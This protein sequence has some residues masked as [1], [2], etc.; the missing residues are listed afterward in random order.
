MSGNESVRLPRPGASILVILMGSLGD[1][2]RGFCILAP[3]KARLPECRVS[4]L[5]ESKWAA[6]ARLQSGIDEL[7][8]LEREHG[9]RAAVEIL[10]RLPRGRYDISLDLQRHLKSGICSRASG[11]PRRIAFHPRNSKEFNYLF[12]TE[13]VERCPADFPKVYHYL[14]FLD[15][16]GVGWSEPLDFGLGAHARGPL[17]P[18]V[19]ALGRPYAALVMGS[20]KSSKD[21]TPGGYEALARSIIERGLGVVFLGDR[22]QCE[23]A[24]AI[25]ARL[26]SPFVADLTGATALGELVPL[27]GQAVAAAGPDSGPG[28]ISAAVGTPYVALFGPTCVRRVAPYRCESLVVQAESGLVSDI[29]A[30]QVWQKLGGLLAADPRSLPR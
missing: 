6:L 19:G 5:V 28:H 23:T 24:A 9:V 10:H 17:P 29:R 1:L 14:K 22:S 4:W 8:V 13:Y 21:W 27:L 11:A 2:T 20:S 16:L 3:L 7:L 15:Q 25:F 18:S 30:E 12:N 26:R